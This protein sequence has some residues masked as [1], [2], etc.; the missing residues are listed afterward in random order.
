MSLIPVLHCMLLGDQ[1]IDWSTLYIDTAK[2][3]VTKYLVT[4]LKFKNV[5]L[6]N[7]FM[8]WEFIL[9]STSPPTKCFTN[10]GFTHAR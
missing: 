8:R 5:V 2:T 3:N 10:T 1:D 6:E 7:K 4:I 9:E